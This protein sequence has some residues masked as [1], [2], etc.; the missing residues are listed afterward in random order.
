M[1]SLNIIKVTIL[2][3]QFLQ[4][5]ICSWY[6]SKTFRKSFSSTVCYCPEEMHTTFQYTTLH[7]KIANPN[8]SYVSAK[9]VSY[10]MVYGKFLENRCPQL[11]SLDNN[12]LPCWHYCGEALNG[13]L[14][15][16]LYMKHQRARKC[17]Y[18]M[19]NREH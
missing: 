6:Q 8:Q 7:F 10:F 14:Q 4:P 13:P 17:L 9:L 11:P 12:R 18:T 16:F 1:I 3:L 5:T 15:D 19:H 2:T